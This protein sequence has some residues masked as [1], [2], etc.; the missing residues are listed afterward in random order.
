[1]APGCAWFAAATP[2]GNVDFFDGGT[3]KHLGRLPATSAFA[4]TPDSKTIVREAAG[5]LG[6]SYGL[7]VWDL[8][9][10]KPSTVPEVPIGSVVGTWVGKRC[11]LRHMNALGNIPA[12]YLLYDLDFH[13]H[14]H[15]FEPVLGFDVRNDPFGRAWMTSPKPAAGKV[16]KP[17]QLAGKDGFERTL[18]FGPG[19]T[20]RVSVDAGTDVASRQIARQAAETLQRRG[21]KIGR[22]G[23]LLRADHTVGR[24][25]QT[26]SNPAT[27]KEDSAVVALN[28][29]WR[30]IGPDGTEV[31]QGSEGGTFDPFR[32]KYVVV[33]SRKGQFG[34]NSSWS[35]VEL[36]FGGKNAESAQ[37][38]EILEHMLQR[39]NALPPE[40]PVCVAKGANGLERLP[41]LG[42]LDSP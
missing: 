17:V 18:A 24:G 19:S 34:T 13:T 25:S 12:R 21:V 23:W 40:F 22:D 38:E 14:T 37:L 35:M 10:G 31:W 7:Q 1:M 39:R 11:A 32:S 3:G 27:G 20:I 29:T 2:G 8:E 41:I 30:L 26:F 28:I 6:T 4:I 16:W 42:K 15:A 9:T 5:G 33:G 36:D